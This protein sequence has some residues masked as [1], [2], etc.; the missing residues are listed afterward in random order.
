[1]MKK[2]LLL[3]LVIIFFGFTYFYFAKSDYDSR[4]EK[5]SEFNYLYNFSTYKSYSQYQQKYKEDIIRTRPY[6]SK[7]EINYLAPKDNFPACA[8][9][10]KTAVLLIHGLTD[11]PFSMSDIGKIFNQK[12][13]FTRSLIIPGHALTPGALLSVDY[14]DWIRAVDFALNDLRK[15]FDYVIIASLST[16]GALAINRAYNQDDDFIKA[17]ILFSPS[18]EIKSLNNFWWLAKIMS[19]IGD[20]LPRLAWMNIRDDADIYKYESFPYKSAYELYKLMKINEKLAKENKLNIPIFMAISEDDKTVDFSASLA[21]FEKNGSKKK[22]IIYSNAENKNTDEITYVK[23]PNPDKKILDLSHVAL[24]VSKDNYYYGEHPLYVNCLHYYSDKKKYNECK[25]AKD[26]YQGE[27]TKT[28]LQK[29]MMRRISY[30]PD[31]DD[32]KKELM[33]FVR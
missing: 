25:N 4:L 7:K 28:N 12:C 8:E 2:L 32:L 13:Y 6:L 18:I 21:W 24:Q 19:I 3:F 11:S 26:I 30:N 27:I 1:M 22:I 20:Y 5:N 10:K 31:F 23:I 17:L 16:G 29:Y 33:Q 15:N 14:T 9:G